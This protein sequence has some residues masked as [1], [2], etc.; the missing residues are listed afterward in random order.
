MDNNSPSH[1]LEEMEKKVDE[2]HE[3]VSEIHEIFT[4]LAAALNNPM[5][6]AMMPPNL[7][8]ML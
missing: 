6:K 2:I 7:R 4:G 1:R 3:K 5:I 8:E